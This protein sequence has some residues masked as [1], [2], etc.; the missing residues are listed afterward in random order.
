MNILG[1]TYRA[2]TR[3]TYWH[4][5][6]MGF[7]AFL[8]FFFFIRSEI[9]VHSRVRLGADNTYVSYSTFIELDN[10]NIPVLPLGKEDPKETCESEPS[11]KNMNSFDKSM[12]SAHSLIVTAF[13][14]IASCLTWTSPRERESEQLRCLPD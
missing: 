4:Y 8:T 5:H 13:S 7:A 10:D 6:C 11:D 1:T 2:V 12:N 9:S 3:S 14:N